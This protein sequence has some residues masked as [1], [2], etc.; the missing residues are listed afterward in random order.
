MH[1]D[2][3]DVATHCA[4]H[5]RWFGV[6]CP[7]CPPP[8]HTFAQGDTFTVGELS[9]EVRDVSGHCPGSVALFTPGHVFTGDALFAG[10]IGRVD[11]PHSDAWQLMANLREQLMTLPD[12]TIV[13]PGHGETTTIG[14]ERHHNPFRAEWEKRL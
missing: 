13:Y 11:L 6:V 9:F 1:P 8:D 4:E 2:T 3:V 10:S 14:Q 12:D 7:D 5:A